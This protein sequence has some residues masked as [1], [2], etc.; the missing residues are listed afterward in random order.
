MTDRAIIEQWKDPYMPMKALVY[1]FLLAI[2]TLLIVAPAFANDAEIIK[3]QQA[4]IQQQQ[5][6]LQ[7]QMDHQMA[8]AQEQTRGMALFGAGNAMINGMNQGFNNMRV[9]PAPIPFQPMALPFPN[10]GR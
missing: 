3:Q 7:Q 2:L 10:A 9:Q 6:M 1:A 8:L 4:I 5:A